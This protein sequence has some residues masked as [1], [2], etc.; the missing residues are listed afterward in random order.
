MIKL[1]KSTLNNKVKGFSAFIQGY[2]LTIM[3]SAI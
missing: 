1:Y 2:H 3:A